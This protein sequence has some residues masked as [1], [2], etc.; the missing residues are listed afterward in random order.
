LCLILNQVNSVRNVRV[1]VRVIVT[2]R[3]AVYRQSVRLGDKL[4]RLTT[5]NFIFQ[6]NVC[7]YSPCVTCSLTREWVYRLQLLLALASAIIIGSE[8]HETH[9]HIKSLKFET[10]N[11]EG[12]VPIFMSPGNGLVIAPG[13]R[14][15]FRRLLR[16][17]GL[18][19]WYSTQ[20]PYGIYV[21]RNAKAYPSYIL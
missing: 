6:L 20:L 11:L 14:L 16:L 8:S 13:T 10:P 1:R 9:D 12:Q 2:L 3:L 4:L 5:S 21:F 15:P 17:A 18:R 7:G 19:V